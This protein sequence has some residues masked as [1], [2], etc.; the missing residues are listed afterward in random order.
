MKVKDMIN[1]LRI[2]GMVQLR[3]KDNFNIGIFETYSEGLNS[4][5]DRDVQEWFPGCPPKDT[6]V[7][8]VIILGET[9]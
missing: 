8:F 1:Y 2:P 4:Y 6:G 3:N 5:M 9:K 7:D